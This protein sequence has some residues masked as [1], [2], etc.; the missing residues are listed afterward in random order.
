[1]RVFVLVKHAPSPESTLRVGA[2]GKSVDPVCLTYDINDWDKY[3]V[4]EAVRLKEKYGGEVVAVSVGVNCDATLKKC[5][6]MGVDRAV[7]VPVEAGFDPY[8]TAE[9]IVDV[10]RGERF[11][12]VISGFMSQDTNNALV[13]VLAAAMLDLP[14]ATAVVELS[15]E[16]DEVRAVREIEGGYREEV[17]LQLPCLVTVQSGINEPRYVSIM[18]IKA[19]RSKE[20]REH[21][22]K[23]RGPS[24]FV[25]RIYVPPTRRAEILK[26]SMP[27][28]A[29]KLVEL[30]GSKGVI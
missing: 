21:V 13:G 22:V 23:L 17:F 9:A 18:G 24:V 19:A 11:D 29:E 10:L 14:F 26:G 15:V 27:E 7:K 3:A 8:Q 20:L 25:E 6:A 28:V 5:L 30:I 16:G 2:D 1:M 12:I 4:E